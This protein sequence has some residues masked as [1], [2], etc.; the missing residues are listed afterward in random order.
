MAPESSELSTS[1]S[2]ITRGGCHSRS[3]GQL[4]LGTSSDSS[5]SEVQNLHNYEKL[6]PL[7]LQGIRKILAFNRIR[8]YR[9]GSFLL[10]KKN[11]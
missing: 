5:D 11:F 8:Y 6:M 10:A 2:V 4:F 1:L 3:S 7:S 9:I